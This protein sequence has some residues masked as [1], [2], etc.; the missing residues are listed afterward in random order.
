MTDKPKYERITSNS[1]ETAEL[2]E[3]LL[4]HHIPY[5]VNMMR[6][7]YENL[8]TGSPSRLFRNALIESFHIHARNLMEFFTNDRQCVV[9]PTIYVEKTYR[10]NKIFMPKTLENKISQQIVHIT[11]QRTTENAAKLNDKERDDTVAALE[12]QILRFERAL[13]DNNRAI[14]TAGLQAMK[15]EDE[16]FVLV[17]GGVRGPTNHIS[18]LTAVL[19]PTGPAGPVMQ[20]ERITLSTQEKKKP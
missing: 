9:D 11:R 4:G 8:K 5:E 1:Q 6:T 2:A 16:L 20:S 7:L 18:S 3:K 12:K 17:T 14:W 19:G 10:V 15:V 13:T